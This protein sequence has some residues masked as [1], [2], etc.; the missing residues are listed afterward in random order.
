MKNLKILIVLIGLFFLITSCSSESS[1]G[2]GTMRV[3]GK[4]TYTNPA[5]GRNTTTTLNNDVVLTSFKINVNEISFKYA[6][7]DDDDDNENGD[8][9]ND[10]GDDDH[11]G[12]FDGDDEVELNGPWELDLLNQIAPVTTVSVPNGTYEEVELELGK[13]LVSTSPLYNKTVE[14]RG[15]INGIPFV[16]W[17]DFEQDLEID[18]EDAG[19]NLVVSNNSFDLV[20]NFDLNQLLS[21]VDLSAAVDGNG[22][23]IIEIGP[24]DTDG[25]NALALTLNEHLGDCGEMEGGEHEDGDDD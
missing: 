19:Q 1:A 17:H 4:A 21:E 7:S 8:N 18:Y 24:N 3:I 12:F 13:N 10:N 16:F 25:N 9:D 6:E 23:G 2:Y 11:D 5:A 14:I 20:F 15:T 22:N